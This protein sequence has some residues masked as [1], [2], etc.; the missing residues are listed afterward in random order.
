MKTYTYRK[1]SPKMIEQMR[2]L[3]SSG[4]F[5]QAEIHHMTGISRTTI[6]KYC[7]DIIPKQCTSAAEALHTLTINPRPE[8]EPDPPVLPDSEI[9]IGALFGKGGP[10]M[11]PRKK[12]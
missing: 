1:I 12:E 5:N 2:N 10:I 6:R 8:P 7:R 3:L 9:N 4:K 11:I